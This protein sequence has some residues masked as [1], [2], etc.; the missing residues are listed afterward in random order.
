MLEQFFGRRK[1]V[2]ARWLQKQLAPSRLVGKRHPRSKLTGGLFFLVDS[3]FL[4]EDGAAD[5]PDH[6]NCSRLVGSSAYMG[7]PTEDRGSRNPL[8][9]WANCEK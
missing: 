8:L 5:S 6:T 7:C 3:L 9:K 2:N 1:D 4:R